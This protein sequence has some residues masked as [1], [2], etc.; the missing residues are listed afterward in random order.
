MSLEFSSILIGEEEPMQPVGVDQYGTHRFLENRI[1]R[2]M[3][4]FSRPR[5]FGLNEMASKAASGDY[6]R[7]EQEQFAQLIGYSVDGYADLSFVS[8]KSA[9]RAIALSEQLLADSNEE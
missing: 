8:N 5:G 1:V 4:E 9:D 6:S 3:L 7:S 2:D